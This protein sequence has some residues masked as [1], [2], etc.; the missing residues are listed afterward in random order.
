MLKR[1]DCHLADFA[2][3]RVSDYFSTGIFL[4]D[5]NIFYFV[6]LSDSSGLFGQSQET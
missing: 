6:N 1:V 4:K 5:C 2:L 3:G